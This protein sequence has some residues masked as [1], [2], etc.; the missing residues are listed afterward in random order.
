MKRLRAAVGDEKGVA[1]MHVLVFSIF[2]V[3]VAMGLTVMMLQRYA[4][5]NKATESN[6]R[7]ASDAGLLARV[8]S[9]WAL[10]TINSSSPLSGY[11]TSFT[12]SVGACTCSRS[13]C[14]CTCAC[15][16]SGQ[17]TLTVTGSCGGSYPACTSCQ[18]GITSAP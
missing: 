15:T 17:P 18:L 12:D 9:G 10:N 6:A 8:N 2:V 3:S 1:L 11:C 16:A 13:N 7:R 14:A 5:T 4:A